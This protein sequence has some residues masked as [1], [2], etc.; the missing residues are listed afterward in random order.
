MKSRKTASFPWN[1]NSMQTTSPGTQPGL[2]GVAAGDV[3]WSNISGSLPS[4]VC[5]DCPSG[6]CQEFS[7]YALSPWQVLGL[8]H[9]NE[10]PASYYFELWLSS[11]TEDVGGQHWDGRGKAGCLV[12]WLGWDAEWAVLP[13]CP[14]PCLFSRFYVLKGSC[15][16]VSCIGT[17]NRTPPVANLCH[18]C[19]VHNNSMAS[20]TWVQLGHLFLWDVWDS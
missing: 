12:P 14:W 16:V 10:L 13:G 17:T 8:C 19:L 6:P 11:G 5:Q 18:R 15:R 2:A 7:F 3:G 4:I 1:N 9:T 20:G